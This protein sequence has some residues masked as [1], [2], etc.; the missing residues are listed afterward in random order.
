[1][2]TTSYGYDLTIG[3]HTDRDD[4][5]VCCDSDM[6]GQDKDGDY[7]RYTCGDCAAVVTIDPSGLV[8]DIAD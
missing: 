3:D 6:T 4:I 8:S 2:P 7:R 5:P 1:M